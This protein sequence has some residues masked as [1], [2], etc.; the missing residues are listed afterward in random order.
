M[1]NQIM[2]RQREAEAGERVS[3]LSLFLSHTGSRPSES[4]LNATWVKIEVPGSLLRT[5]TAMRPAI[6]SNK[7]SVQFSDIFIDRFR[8]Y[9]FLIQRL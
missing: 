3:S 1:L 4:Q 7:Q 9:F 5:A 8:V 2:H 6:P